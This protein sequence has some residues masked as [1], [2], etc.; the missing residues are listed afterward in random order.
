MDR[1][2]LF[3][4]FQ[5]APS[6]YNSKYI[7]NL[8][9]SIFQLMVSLRSPGEGRQSTLVLTDLPQNDVGLE[10][11]ALFEVNGAVRMSKRNIAYLSGVEMTTS[12][13]TVT[14]NIS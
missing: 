4:I 8:V 1:R 5:K 6:L 13:G 9:T 7:D 2:L 3:P 10:E 11:G 12:V 14:V